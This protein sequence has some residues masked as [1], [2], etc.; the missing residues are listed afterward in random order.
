M[1]ENPI[2]GS[3]EDNFVQTLHPKRKNAQRFLAPHYLRNQIYGY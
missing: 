2:K 3:P 1:P